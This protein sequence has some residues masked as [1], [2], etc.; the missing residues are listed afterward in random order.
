MTGDHS[1]SPL[2]ISAMAGIFP[3]A[4]DLDSN[5]EQYWQAIRAARVAPLTD[6]GPRWGVP[7]ER[8]LAAKPGVPDTTYVDHAFCL[9][10]DAGKEYSDLPD[11]QA[12][13]GQATLR[14]LLS[15][16]PGGQPARL[17]FVLAT[18]WTGDSYF[19]RAAHAVLGKEPEIELP[20][21]P[22]VGLGPDSQLAA[23]SEGLDGP[24]FAIDTAC[25]SS[26]YGLDLARRLI[27]TGR[28]DAVAVM[29]LT[30]WLPPF[31]FM[32]FS[33]LMALS[34]ERQLLPYAANASG[35][36]IGEACGVILVE[37]LSRALA[38]GRPVLAVLRTLGLSADGADRS[39]FAPGKD[40]QRLMYS[41]SYRDFT[42]DS[43]D[44]LEGH[45][46]GTKLGDETE[47]TIMREFFGPHYG[48]DRPLPIGS[49]KGLIGHTLAAAG[50]ASIIKALLMLKAK[51]LPPHN[52]VLPNPTLADSALTLLTEPTPWPERADRP[53]RAGVSAFGFGG[54][55]AHVLLEEYRPENFA[56]ATA[57]AAPAWRPLAIV[58]FDAAYGPSTTLGALKT[59]LDQ[60]GVFGQRLPDN[61]TIEAQGLR[62]GPNF[63]KRLD[64]YQLLLT[65]LAHRIA[66]RRSDLANDENAGVVMGSNLGGALTLRVMRRAI[67]L[68][69]HRP[70]AANVIARADQF[71]PKQS[72]ESIASCL[73]NMS[74]G[75]PTFHLNLRGFHQTLSGGPGLFWESLALAGNW[76]GG[77]CDRLLL[78]AGRIN[79]TP[80]EQGAEGAAFF[81]LQDPRLARKPVATLHAVVPA[82]A[83]PD[84]ASAC[85][86]AGLPPE[87]FDWRGVSDISNTPLA[88]AG[89]ADVLVSALLVAKRWAAIEV[90]DGEALR[91]TLLLEKHSEPALSPANPQLPLNVTVRE[92]PATPVASP[93]TPRPFSGSAPLRPASGLRISRETAQQWLQTTTVAM[94]G[95]FAAQR[96]SLALAPEYGSTGPITLAPAKTMARMTAVLPSAQAPSAAPPTPCRKLHR[97]ERHVAIDDP[98]VAA[99]GSLSAILRVDESHP[100]FFD[101]P[102]DHLPGI[103]MLEGLLQL[104]EWSDTPPAGQETYI[105]AV[106]LSFRRFCEKDVPAV[107]RMAPSAAGR[108]DGTV[109]Q[110]ESVACRFSLGIAHA[111][112]GPGVAEPTEP[113]RGR[114]DIAL[115][116]KH[117]AENVLVTPLFDLPD[118]A[119]ACETYAPPAEHILADGS[120]NYYGMLYLL[121]T[122]RQFLMLVAHT[123]WEAPLGM[124]MNLL[125]IQLD[126]ERPAPRGLPITISYHPSHLAD[127][128]DSAIVLVET[129]LQSGGQDI[130]KAAIVA[131]ALTPDAYK[132]QRGSEKGE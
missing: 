76:L 7:R 77:G 47:L 118:G 115:L 64:P 102:L 108:F 90:R 3:G 111:P 45:G 109:S 30:A 78:G 88:E 43:L 12:R 2:V 95:F 71:G 39:V 60:R 123:V 46:T 28:A 8:Y 37:P 9:P 11:R 29:G 59:D 119:K 44:Y 40:G 113:T 120:R 132:K 97:A 104:A 84:F 33:Q 101:H 98:Q 21:P 26:L 24:R 49:V 87:Q 14:K 10:E 85:A 99:D 54:S 48:S 124:P 80:E 93:P 1:Q 6:L 17:G 89:G 94:R 63:L 55:N 96:A 86:V 38:A 125:S 31:L 4:A 112:A 91:C 32:S 114:P 16:L 20:P 18:E 105:N 23:I 116:H 83:A 42:P 129:R 81:L 130:G 36:M 34:P 107:V 75:Y 53:R 25:A 92:T 121:E 128:Q 50:I 69:R 27:E 74:S 79:K 35:I 67:W 65:E 52:P 103:L 62:M 51:E 122:A 41:R 82:S 58:D 72:L 117:R 110:R 106:K 61:L 131:Q 66:D 19:D 22:A 68:T 5:L 127:H 13:V 126:L 70:E 100:Y 15:N 73:P 57:P 56:E